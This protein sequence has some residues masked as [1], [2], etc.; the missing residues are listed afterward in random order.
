MFCDFRIWRIGK[1]YIV[2]IVDSI[3]YISITSSSFINTG[4]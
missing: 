1:G 3:I 2:K 4:E